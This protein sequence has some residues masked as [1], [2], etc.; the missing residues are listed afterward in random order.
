MALSDLAAEFVT[1]PPEQVRDAIA[2]A[3]PDLVALY[4][5][6]ATALGADWYDEVRASA[7]TTGRFRAIPADLPDQGRLDSLVGWGT[8]P[9][10]ADEPQIEVA[11]SKVAGGFQRIVADAHRDTVI[12]SLARDPQAKGWSRQTTG[13]SCEFC[14]MIAGRGAV[15]NARTALFSSHDDCDC[16]AVP[17]FGEVQQVLPYVPS[18]RFRS[19]ASRDANNARVRAFLNSNT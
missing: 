15:Y 10:F 19:Q 9:L 12:G 5:S 17:K 8:Q 13:K 7:G 16:I 11:Q 6:A 3:L 18:Q 1:G 2:A 14:V 4:G